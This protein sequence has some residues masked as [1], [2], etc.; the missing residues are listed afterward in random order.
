MVGEAYRKALV[1]GEFAEV[2]EGGDGDEACR[3]V[4]F[5]L[6]L[7]VIPERKTMRMECAHS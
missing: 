4:F 1:L 6:L 5:L 7:R 2:E 3:G